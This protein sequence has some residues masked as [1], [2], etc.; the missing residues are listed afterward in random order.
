[1][2][3]P[4]DRPTSDDPD[5]AEDEPQQPDLPLEP[6]AEASDGPAEPVFEPPWEPAPDPTP[7]DVE[8]APSTPSS[9]PVPTWTP[10]VA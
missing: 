7:P 10:E 1:M 6:A 3:N 4:P 8:R 5:F 9:P 2:T